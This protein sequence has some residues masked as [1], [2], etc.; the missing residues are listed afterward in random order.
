MTLGGVATTDLLFVHRKANKRPIDF[1][2]YFP[3]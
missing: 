3:Y 1:Q 2:I